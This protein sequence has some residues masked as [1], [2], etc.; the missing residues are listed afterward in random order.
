[1]AHTDSSRRQSSLRQDMRSRRRALSPAQVRAASRQIARHVL[2]AGRL[3]PGQRIAIY[4][5]RNGEVDP[6]PL[7]RALLQRGC[8]LWLPR[9]TSLRDARMIFAPAVQRRRINRLGIPEPDTCQRLAVHWMHIVLL[10]LVAFDA[11]GNR[12]GQ[13][14]GFYDRA[15]AFRLRRRNWRGPWLLG[16]A[17]RFQRCAPLRPGRYDVSLDAVATEDGLIRFPAE[18]MR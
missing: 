11:S 9:I 16:L 18:S 15:L 17:H 1:M 5:A 7:A 12:L 6:A 8:S 10:P 3:K 13:G 14:A 2:A 4:S